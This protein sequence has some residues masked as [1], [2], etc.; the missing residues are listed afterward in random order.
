MLTVAAKD[1][2]NQKRGVVIIKNIV[3]QRRFFMDRGPKAAQMLK[4]T[5]IKI[6]GLHFCYD[7]PLVHGVLN[8]CAFMLPRDVLVRM[9]FHYGESLKMYFP[10]ARLS[11][12]F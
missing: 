11:P 5:P 4:I 2:E 3:G 9:K 10:R 6:C 12:R 1:E 8:A 7:D